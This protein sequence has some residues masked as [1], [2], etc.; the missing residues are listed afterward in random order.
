MLIPSRSFATLTAVLVGLFLVGGCSATST[1]ESLQSTPVG[2]DAVN[3]TSIQV[4]TSTI[5][6][7]VT[8]VAHVTKSEIV[9]YNDPQS[10][11]PV[12]TFANPTPRGGPLVF[13]VVGHPDLN[14]EWIEVAL[15]IRPNGSKGWVK[16]SEINL[17]T[18]SYRIEVNASKFNLTIYREDQ[19]VLDTVVAIGQ[20][21]TPTPFGQFY[22][23]ELLQ[24]IDSNGPYGSYAYGL[25]GYSDTLDSFNGGEG[26]IGI[27]GTNQPELLGTTVSHGCIRVSNEAIEEMATFLPLGTPV[28]IV[29]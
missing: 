1:P 18:N 4:T 6:D 25:S 10:L 21:E 23:I 15:P 8:L 29:Q 20:G 11:E 7:Y 16:R 14:S 3:T 24:P 27:H 17:T 26:V 22:L 2:A 5:P 13:Q 28:T 12:E 19:P 9:A